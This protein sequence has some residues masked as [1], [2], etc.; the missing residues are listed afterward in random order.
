MYH[1]PPVWLVWNQLYDNLQF[2]LN[3]LIQTS[4]T[5]GQWYSDT[6]PFSIPWTQPFLIRAFVYVHRY[7]CIWTC[8][9]VHICLYICIV[10]M[11][12]AYV[13]VFMYLYILF[14]QINFYMCVLHV[15]CV[16]MSVCLWNM[17]MHICFIYLSVY[18]YP[19]VVQIS[20]L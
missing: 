5:G 10:H 11:Y 4:Q 19:Y 17:S 15:L 8:A 9:F 2:L 13:F 20:V 7:T 18:M 12:C 14:S 16:H 1:W 3:S 6:S